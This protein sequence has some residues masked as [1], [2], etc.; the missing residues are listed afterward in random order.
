M[1]TRPKVFTPNQRL[2]IIFVL[3]SVFNVYIGLNFSYEQ[4]PSIFVFSKVVVLTFLSFRSLLI[5]SFYAFLGR[6]LEK[7]QLTP[8]ALHLL[9]QHS[10]SFFPDDQTIV[11][12]ILRTFPHVIQLQHDPNFFCRYPI[13]RSNI[14]YPSKNPC[15]I[16]LQSDHI[17]LLIIIQLHCIWGGSKLFQRYFVT[18]SPSASYFFNKTR[19]LK[20]MLFWGHPISTYAKCFEKLTFLAP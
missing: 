9:T 16:P 19:K 8:K 18:S 14:A 2:I 11:F 7:L 20:K 12:S 5:T 4:L 6:P 10:V 13:L 1:V 3:M 15:I 17:F